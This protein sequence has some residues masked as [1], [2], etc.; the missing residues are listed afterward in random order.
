VARGNGEHP[1]QADRYQNLLPHD[2]SSPLRGEHTAP[3]LETS[4][5]PP[6][7]QARYSPTSIRQRSIVPHNPVNA[8][9]MTTNPTVEVV[10]LKIAK[11]PCI[12]AFRVLTG[13]GSELI[14]DPDNGAGPF[15]VISVNEA[16]FA[17]IEPV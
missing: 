9:K 3:V 4:F 1:G 11:F 16:K 13:S 17:W 8:P 6:D 2:P 12:H 5:Y 10:F 7:A 15:N 14:I